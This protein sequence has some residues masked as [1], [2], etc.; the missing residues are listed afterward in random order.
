MNI[1]ESSDRPSQ[2]GLITKHEYVASDQ[3]EALS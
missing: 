3:K 2:Q 1:N